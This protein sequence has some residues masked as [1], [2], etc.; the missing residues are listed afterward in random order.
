MLTGITN[1]APFIMSAGTDQR[2]RYWDLLEASRCSV[3]VSTI[4]DVQSE[5]SFTYE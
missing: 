1:K 4:K 5:T 3:V 2:I